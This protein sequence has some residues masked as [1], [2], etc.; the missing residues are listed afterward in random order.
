M[1]RISILFSIPAAGAS[2][3]SVL[4]SATTQF[5][6]E[7]TN[8]SPPSPP[9]L[10]KPH[11]LFGKHRQQHA[12]PQPS[13]QLPTIVTVRADNS[14]TR[15]ESSIVTASSH[16][17]LKVTLSTLPTS[18]TVTAN[19]LESALQTL[20]PPYET[21]KNDTTNLPTILAHLQSSTGTTTPFS[22]PTSLMP[23]FHIPSFTAYIR[24]ALLHPP[25][26]RTNDYQSL[27]KGLSV[28]RRA[29][30]ASTSRAT[31]TRSN[32]YGSYNVDRGEK[33]LKWG[34]WVTTGPAAHSG[35]EMGGMLDAWGRR[36]DT[37]VYGGLM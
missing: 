29:S 6:V 21:E 5:L 37:G 14:I 10:Q 12:T 23:T 34:F 33:T 35:R 8:T 22:R 36:R 2:P 25:T 16:D 3:S 19:A 20:P 15:H 7:P 11:R 32:S 1:S 28:T 24:E 31:S 17:H 30:D 27:C 13:P 9:S 4:R 26:S 18:C